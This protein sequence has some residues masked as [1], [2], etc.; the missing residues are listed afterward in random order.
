MAEESTTPDPVELPRRWLDALNRGDFDAFTSLL[1]PDAVWEATT[2]GTTFEGAMAIRKLAED[3][4]GSYEVYDYSLREVE[5]LGNGV[6]FY[7][8]S[9]DARPAGSSG[10]VQEIWGFTAVLA[11]GLMVRIQ[12]SRDIDQARAAA[13][14]LAQERW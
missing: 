5:H 7:V 10:D 12:S 4:I 13:E 9:F 11:A 1:D 3:I 14:R 8:F 6:V 2:L